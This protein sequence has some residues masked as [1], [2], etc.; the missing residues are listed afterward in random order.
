MKYTI[1]VNMEILLFEGTNMPPEKE[2]VPILTNGVSEVNP[3]T[4]ASAF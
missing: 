1:G 3:F 4:L 2:E